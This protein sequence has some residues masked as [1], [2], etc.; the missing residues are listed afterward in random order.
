MKWLAV[1]L[2]LVAAPALAE[3]TAISVTAAAAALPL[4][5]GGAVATVITDSA[6][7]A[8]V[9][10]AAADLRSDLASLAPANASAST[11]YAVIVGTLGNNA[12]VDRLVAERRI[13]PAPIRGQWEAYLQQVVDHP[14]PGLD[15]ALV[16][17]GSDRR[18]AIFGAYDLSRRAGVS[19]WTWWAD[20][21]LRRRDALFILSGARTDKPVVKYRGIFLNDED[22]ALSGWAK[23]RFGGLNHQFL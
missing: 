10:R 13:D 16:I 21:P 11:R 4:I 19:P 20:V 7:D 5:S 8:G 1:L 15:R 23:A 17:V 12:I 14:A 3:P 9:L 18:G 22:P 6:D 2:L